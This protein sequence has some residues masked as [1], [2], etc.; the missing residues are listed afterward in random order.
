MFWGNEPLGLR[1]PL[2][3]QGDLFPTAE[4]AG[5][6]ADQGSAPVHFAVILKLMKV[7]GAWPKIQFQTCTRG[8]GA[9][10]SGSTLYEGLK[11]ARGLK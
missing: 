11:D 3:D 1:R 4:Q 9:G 5:Q 2:N 6:G 8:G 10:S 7:N